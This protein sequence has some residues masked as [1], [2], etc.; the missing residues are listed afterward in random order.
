MGYLVL[1]RSKVYMVINY[2][3]MLE[4]QKTLQP[5][6]YRVKLQYDSHALSMGQ[7]DVFMR[8]YNKILEGMVEVK[9]TVEGIV[10][11]GIEEGMDGL[12]K[13]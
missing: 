11:L 13:A 8:L 3:V 10:K 1:A 12:W 2:A 6:G 5:G 9:A 7:A 4:V